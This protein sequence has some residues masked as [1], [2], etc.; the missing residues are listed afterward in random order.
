MV[1]RMR[2]VLAIPQ[3]NLARSCSVRFSPE[4][5]IVYFI[6][7]YEYL[8]VTSFVFIDLEIIM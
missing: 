4:I 5:D 3:C 6:S 2:K 7:Y 8:F 1:V